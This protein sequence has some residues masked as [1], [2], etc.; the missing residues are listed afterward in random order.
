MQKAIIISAPS[1]AGKTSIIKQVMQKIPELA[2]SVSAC[3]R[4]KRPG[5]EDGKDYHFLSPDAFKEHVRQ[6]DFVEWEEVYENLFYGTLKSEL[7]R[8]WDQGK[9]PLFEVDIKG[10]LNLKQY[11]GNEALSIFISPPD[12]QTLEQRL[13][14]RGTED[15]ASLRKRIGKAA[16]ELEHAGKFDRVVVNRDLNEAITETLN[17]IQEFMK[18]KNQE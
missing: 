2:F 16:F 11:F 8:I 7:Q 10:G 6:G 14:S 4:E 3:T 12:I 5:E 18:P 13:R 1:G 15:E 17:V 9:M